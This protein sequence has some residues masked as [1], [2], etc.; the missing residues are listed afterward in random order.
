MGGLPRRAA[1]VKRFLTEHPGG[2]TLQ[3]DAGGL[4]NSRQREPE[5]ERL[6]WQAV[7][8]IGLDLLNLTPADAGVLA[9]L[10][11][12]GGKPGATAP[13]RPPQLL[14]ANVFA[15]GRKP[16]APPF[17]VRRAADGTRLVFIGLCEAH[18]AGNP[19]YLVED[20]K[21][22]LANLLP[23]VQSQGS[24]IIVLAYMTPSAAGGLAAAVKG[25][26]ILISG[27]DDQFAVPAYQA[28]GSAT[29]MLQSQFEGRF[30][31]YARLRLSAPGQLTD[32]DP[33]IIITLDR[34]IPD[35]P[36]IAA[37]LERKQAQ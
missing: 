31:G 22:A 15:P 1:F 7:R 27:R 6:M 16:L 32:F 37:L 36:G 9:R 4:F 14:T 13:G 34:S 23:D 24:I 35:D 18:P 28:P 5:N 29:W 25:V 30:L 33:Q 12:A 3:V 8:E 2:V 20:P 10:K 26:N 11:E 17:A 21:Q 19:G